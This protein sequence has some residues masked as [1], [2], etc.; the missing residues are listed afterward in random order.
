MTLSRGE[1][2]LLTSLREQ[3]QEALRV[4]DPA[5]PAMTR[6]FPAPVLGDPAA[7]LEARDA[8]VDELLERRLDALEELESIL[9]RGSSHRGSWRVQ[10]SDEEPMVVLGVLN[11]CRLAIGARIDVEALDRDA[12]DRDDPIAYR[13]A[14]MDHLGWWQEQL[15]A[16]LEPGVD[17]SVEDEDD[18]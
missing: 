7:E 16:V 17:G 8:I 3:L 1:Y 5:D 15:L 12:L 2:E 14:V 9:R 13:L 10:L 18:R 11:D 6:L 4:P